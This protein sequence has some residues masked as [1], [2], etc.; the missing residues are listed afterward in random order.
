VATHSDPCFSIFDSLLIQFRQTQLIQPIGRE[1]LGRGTEHF[2]EL[3]AEVGVRGKVQLGGG[4]FGRVT[5]SD[6]F[7]GQTTL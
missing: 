6:Q 3:A 2:F 5:L 1:A 4:C 7:F